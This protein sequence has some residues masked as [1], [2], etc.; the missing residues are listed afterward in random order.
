MLFQS[1]SWNTD[2]EAKGLMKGPLEAE[3]RRRAD[4]RV[5]EAE[6]L[7]AEQVWPRAHGCDLK[8]SFIYKNCTVYDFIEH[9]ESLK[10]FKRILRV[11][12]GDLFDSSPT[13]NTTVAGRLGAREAF[14]GRH[15]QW[16]SETSYRAGRCQV[17]VEPKVVHLLSIIYY[18]E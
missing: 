1:F 6:L 16:S 2:Q 11:S 14:P 7:H 10:S 5:R 9:F 3:K 13:P 12:W 8:R 17:G 18:I 15:L 4:H